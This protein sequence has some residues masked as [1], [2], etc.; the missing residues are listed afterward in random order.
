MRST[1]S[2]GRVVALVFFLLVFIASVFATYDRIQFIGNSEVTTG[3]VVDIIEKTTSKV[4]RVFIYITRD[5]EVSVIDYTDETGQ[6][7]RIE[8]VP[9]LKKAPFQLGETVKIRYDKEFPW[10]G[11]VDSFTNVFGFVVLLY[12]MTVVFFM[13]F[14]YLNNQLKIE[15]AATINK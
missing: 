13:L 5:I 15:K 14:I 7:Q 2:S 10:N 9:F 12:F 4:D 3:K 1:Y 6:T 8:E 11:V